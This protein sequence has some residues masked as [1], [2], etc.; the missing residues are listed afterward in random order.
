MGAWGRDLKVGKKGLAMTVMQTEPTG[1]EI[2]IY[3]E[4]AG[5]EICAIT[6]ERVKLKRGE[7]IFV[8]PLAGS[9]HVFDKQTG[10]RID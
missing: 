10:L 8:N 9:T 4:A 1:P 7:Q 6:T 5:V 3:G 2:H